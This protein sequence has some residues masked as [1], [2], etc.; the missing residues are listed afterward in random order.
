[1][2]IKNRDNINLYVN[3]I[4]KGLNCI[5][6]HGGP[7][8]WSKDF[9]LFCGDL[10]INKLNMIYTDQRG[11]GRSEGDL[12]SD[13]SIDSLVEDIEEIRN[14]LNLDKVILLAHSFGGIIAAAYVNKYNE[15]V[16]GLI[17]MNCTL[18][19]KESLKSQIDKGYELLGIPNIGYGNNLIETWKHITFDLVKNNIY[20]KLQYKSYN[21]YLNI[22]NIDKAILNTSMSEQAFDN[23]R[24][25]YD[26]RDI[27]CKIE[28]P[29]LIIS[30]DG[31]YAIGKNHAK[32]FNF[33][34]SLY[35]T[36]DGKHNPYVENRSTLIRILEKFILNFK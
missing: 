22:E 10:L 1:M 27:S 14:K 9:E 13:Y 21:N 8:A 12:Y 25:F 31:D 34:N 23:D 35:V 2:F 3:Q 6:I 15:N 18:D 29:T 5:Y 20:Y 7:G 17:L 28:I 30:G 19:M 11:C 36:I 33:K 16:N 4:G 26:Y 24:Y 32:T